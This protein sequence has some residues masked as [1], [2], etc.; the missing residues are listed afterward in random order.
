MISVIIPN[1]NK[2]KYIK[3]TL[4]SVQNQDFNDWEC[5]IIDDNSNDSSI[6]IIK[7]FIKND[8][9]FLFISNEKNYGAG[10]CRNLGIKLSKGNFII[11][12]DADDLIS[13]NCLSNRIKQISKNILLDFVVFPMG[14][15]NKIVGDN[16]TIWN[17]FKGNHLKRFLSHDLPWAICS[18][19]WKKETLNH[20]R[21]F[22]ED[23]LRLQDV[24]LHSRAL[25]NSFS[26]TTH[27]NFQPDCFYRIDNSRIQNYLLHC[28]ND[29]KGKINF[30][31]YFNDTKNNNLYRKSL[32]GTYFECYC[33]TYNLY[34]IDKI[35]RS[36]VLIVLSNIDNSS[37]TNIFNFSSN[38]II[39]FYSYLKI[40]KIYFK[41]MDS[42]FKFLFMI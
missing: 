10:Y 30:I 11:F 41:G 6:K 19:I 17:K 36:D 32:R 2:D 4:E 7:E 33:Y 42:I 27:S 37:F 28:L 29:I 14:T 20:L 21:G 38:Y 13:S 31:N 15:F 23:F 40:K 1:Y 9:R 18:V 35:S 5:I 24:E 3:K 25:I 39:R 26:Y 34:K 22:N 16:N 12:L 8:S